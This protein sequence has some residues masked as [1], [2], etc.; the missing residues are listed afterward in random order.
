MQPTLAFPTLL[1][2]SLGV[3]HKKQTLLQ[4]LSAVEFEKTLYFTGIQRIP[5][6]SMI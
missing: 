2:R 4:V 1:S 5:Y 6:F 3:E